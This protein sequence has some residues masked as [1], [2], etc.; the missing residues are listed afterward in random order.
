MLAV[1]LLVTRPVRNCCTSVVLEHSKILPERQH[2]AQIAQ[3]AGVQLS[4]SA[5][6][7][8]TAPLKL[9]IESLQPRIC[10]I[11][12][13][14][15]ISVPI[16]VADF[17][18]LSSLP[19]IFWLLLFYLYLVFIYCW[20][21]YIVP[22]VC[23]FCLSVVHLSRPVQLFSSTFIQLFSYSVIQSLNY[24]DIQKPPCSL[25][26]PNLSIIYTTRPPL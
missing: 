2:S 12:F 9:Q 24:S 17:C 5:N 3:A 15:L 7:T 21:Q 16:S 19:L 6:N 14:F 25:A 26:L 4:V 20:L 18:H 10:C 23:W 22:L 13:L 1:S 11:W 8:V